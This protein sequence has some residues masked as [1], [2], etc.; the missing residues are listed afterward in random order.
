MAKMTVCKACGKEIA[1]SAKACPNCG[2]K[3]K[4]HRFLFFL[5]IVVIVVIA[6]AAMGGNSSP[7][8]SS[9]S[10]YTSMSE[11]EVRSG[12]KAVNYE[13]VARNPG[14]YKG[15]L[16]T[17][18]GKVIQVVEGNTVVLRITQDNP[19]E[20]FSSDTWYVTYKAPAGASKILVDD[21]MTVFGECTG[22]T[23]YKS[24]LGNQITIPSMI[25]LYYDM[26]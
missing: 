13:D 3:Q 23:S 16:V 20:Y 6:V 11:T 21:R 4:H 2:A 17:F 22:T 12:S 7:S 1:K 9:K 14:K 5:V 25:L 10:K 8:P 24:V 15:S 26:Q 19:E 18:T